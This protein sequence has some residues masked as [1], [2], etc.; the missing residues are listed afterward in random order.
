[1]GRVFQSTCGVYR[2]DVLAKYIYTIV[3]TIEEE[4]DLF[5]Q[6]KFFFWDALPTTDSFC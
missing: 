2:N 6:K 3:R 4:A 1:M 5:S